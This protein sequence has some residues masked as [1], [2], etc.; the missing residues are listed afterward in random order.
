MVIGATI[1]WFSCF[2]PANMLS[3]NISL[4]GQRFDESANHV[5][6]RAFMF[7]GISAMLAEERIG[8]CYDHHVQVFQQNDQLTAVSPGKVEFVVPHRG[9]PPTIAVSEILKTRLLP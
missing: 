3:V 6:D 9:R 2:S 7:P 8:S 4:A 1:V 5:H